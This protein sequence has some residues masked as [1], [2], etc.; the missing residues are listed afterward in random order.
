MRDLGP[1]SLGEWGT[2]DAPGRSSA[3]CAPGSPA[4]PPSAPALR[5][6]IEEAAAVLRRLGELSALARR[7]GAL[8]SGRIEF[9]RQL[10]SSDPRTMSELARAGSVSRQHVR[11][12]VH[13]LAGGGYVEYLPN[14]AHKRSPLIRLTALGRDQV[15]EF[16]G[17]EARLF[18]RSAIDVGAADVQRAASVLRRVRIGLQ[19]ARGLPQS[20][21][22]GGER[23]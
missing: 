5:A 2:P 10:A 19:D 11:A 3:A 4:H 22:G 17:R 18:S 16:E 1:L 9:L 15:D 14:P 6:L 12:L 13:D 21:V 20:D 23:G 7:K 8:S